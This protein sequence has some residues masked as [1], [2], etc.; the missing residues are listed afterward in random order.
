MCLHKERTVAVCD[1]IQQCVHTVQYVDT[2]KNQCKYCVYCR[3]HSWVAEEL[4]HEPVKADLDGASWLGLN[5]PLTTQ[6]V[7]VVARPPRGKDDTR[8]PWVVTPTRSWRGKVVEEWW[9]VFRE[10]KIIQN[11]TKRRGDKCRRE[12]SKEI[13]S[14]FTWNTVRKTKVSQHSTRAAQRPENNKRKC[15]PF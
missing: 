11:S 2:Q 6:G 9:E 4:S 12:K 8:R 5:D 10:K 13:Q 14:L 1:A 15:S 3:F 7:F